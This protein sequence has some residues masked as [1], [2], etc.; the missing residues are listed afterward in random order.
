[1][2]SLKQA[3]KPTPP[4][5]PLTALERETTDIEVRNGS[6][7][8]NLAH[9]TRTLL[10]QEGFEVSKIGNHIDFGAADT[11]IY[12]RPEA[13]RVARDLIWEIFPQGKLEPSAKLQD[14]VGIKVLLGRDLL[15][16]PLTMAR[17]ASAGSEA[18][19]PA[20]QMT[21]P[22]SQPQRVMSPLAAE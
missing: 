9:Q 2:I 20:A 14:G 4:I 3:T 6:G 17:I 12:Y 16:Q 19:L 18:P 22:A 7:I 10:G 5:P 11:V 15:D 21:R 1:M 13:E 8:Q